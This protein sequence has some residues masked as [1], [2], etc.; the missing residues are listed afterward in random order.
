MSVTTN[1]TMLEKAIIEQAKAAL[2]RLQ[3]LGTVA[4]SDEDRCEAADLAAEANAMIKLALFNS[5]LGRD[6]AQVLRQMEPTVARALAAIRKESP[7]A[8]H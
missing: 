8:L 5:G 2:H 6:A 7:E 3:S 4:L 1:M